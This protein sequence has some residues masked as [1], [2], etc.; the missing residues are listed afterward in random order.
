VA[1]PQSYSRKLLFYGYF[2]LRYLLAGLVRGRRRVLI[3]GEVPA[4]PY[5]IWKAFKL[6]GLAMVTSGDH[7]LAFCHRDHTLGD[8]RAGAINGRC[9][10]IS[11]S[12]VAESFRE[13]FGY[14]LAVDP[15][16][17]SGPM[18]E[19]SETNAAHDGAVV[20]GPMQP[21]PGFVYQKLIANH[22]GDGLVLDIRPGIV[23]DEI[24]YVF[25]KYRPKD[26]RFGLKSTRIDDVAAREVFSESEQA[27]IIRLC[28]AVGLDFGELD[29]LRDETDGRIYIV[30][31]SKTPH[32]PSRSNQTLRAVRCMNRAG[33]SFARQ[34]LARNEG[35]IAVDSSPPAFR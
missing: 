12:R 20:E 2:H 18:V 30:D 16:T 23:G 24:P 11:K 15:A 28:K 35:A 21:R 4:K 6:N 5:F 10:D 25:M 3:I 14:D 31:V 26:I 8:G 27:N 1:N 33:E 32:S 9:V 22:A 7:D 34:F 19:K 17:H 29:V 13:I